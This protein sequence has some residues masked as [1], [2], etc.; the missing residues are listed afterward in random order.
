MAN[1][2]TANFVNALGI[3]AKEITVLDDDNKVLFE[4]KGAETD[5]D[6]N[7]SKGGSVIMAGWK[8]TKDSLYGGDPKTGTY[9]K[10]QIPDK[11]VNVTNSL[12]SPFTWDKSSGKLNADGSLFKLELLTA[13]TDSTKNLQDDYSLVPNDSSQIKLRKQ[14]GSDT[15]LER[16]NYYVWDI[17]PKVQD[18][19]NKPYLAI[20]KLTYQKDT[21]LYNFNIYLSG[22]FNTVSVNNKETSVNFIAATDIYNEAKLKEY[23][24]KDESQLLGVLCYTV[25]KNESSISTKTDP[26]KTN[27]AYILATDNTNMFYTG[28]LN[29]T[30]PQLNKGDYFYIIQ[31][32]RQATPK[33][34]SGATSTGVSTT[35]NDIKKEGGSV[36]KYNRGT[37]FI[38]RQIDTS[39]NV[40]DV[41]TNFRVSEL[42]NLQSLQT[43]RAYGTVKANK[44]ECGS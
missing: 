32:V 37:F 9:T 4:A 30:Y 31:Y 6:G 2:V 5:K 29:H 41:S 24:F 3:T 13:E 11:N 22:L 25:T 1:R 44:I 7:I 43:L 10:I 15:L 40:F 35:Y 34:I 42:G 27:P 20:V 33:V 38:E 39:K 28:K 21:P 14:E 36:V 8:A 19:D 17:T 23:N 18:N 16:D 26:T 12:V